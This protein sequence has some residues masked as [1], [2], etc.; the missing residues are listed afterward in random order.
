MNI[1]NTNWR[2]YFACKIINIGTRVMPIELRNVRGMNNLML[3]G[4]IKVN[5]RSRTNEPTN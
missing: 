5:K 4:N 3:T 1:F 2:F